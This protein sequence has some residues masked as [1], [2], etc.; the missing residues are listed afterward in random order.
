M[1]NQSLKKTIIILLVPGLI[2]SFFLSIMLGSVVIPLDHTLAILI[3]AIGIPIEPIWTPA[4][5]IIIIKYRLPRALMAVIV[6]IMLSI[7]GVASQ[8][9]F[10]NPI[11]DPYIIGISSAAGFGAAFVIVFGIFFLGKFTLPL[12]SFLFSLGSV[13]IIYLLSQRRQDLSIYSLLLSGIALSYIFS[14]MISFILYI[15]ADKSHMII[16]IL[17]GHLWGI[18]WEEVYISIIILAICF[19]I[20][21]FYGLD[22]NL[23]LF[24]DSSAQSMGVNVKFSKIV[25]LII[26]TLLSATA[27][28]FC[29]T[30]GFLGLIV[31]HIARIFYGPD[32][33]KLIPL[34]GLIGA[35]LLLLADLL[36]RI[37]IP[38]LEIPVGIF[39]SLMGGPFFIY[40]VL[41]KKKS[42]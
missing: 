22:M 39:T 14:S 42:G 35:I 13:A 40:L 20:L 25:I 6:G 19:P 8:N 4:E 9:L 16:T 34:S 38:P 3:N 26:M 31:P 30:I 2:L 18:G 24:G 37:L 11:A 28:A 41:K 32:H 5:Q 27:V 7:A 12:F 36:A 1:K 29:G 15:S 17:L 23:L 10:K 33:R 21:G